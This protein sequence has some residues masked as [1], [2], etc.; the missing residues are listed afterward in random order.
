MI[1][2]FKQGF[3]F[4]RYLVGM[5]AGVPDYEKYL[6]HMKTDHP[7]KKP[8]TRKD[9]FDQVQKEKYGGNRMNRCC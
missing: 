3:H 2:K 7:D 4:F 8:M 6:Q 5:I 1:E 9:F